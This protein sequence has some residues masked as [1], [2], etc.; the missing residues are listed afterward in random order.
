[1][2]AAKKVPIRVNSAKKNRVSKTNVNF[3]P[4][5]LKAS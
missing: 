1:M 2:E 3:G 5:G 4:V